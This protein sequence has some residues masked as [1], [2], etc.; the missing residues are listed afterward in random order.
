MSDDYVPG[1]LFPQR[2]LPMLGYVAVQHSQMSHAV[3]GMICH[4][5]N[6]ETVAA[7][8]I[9]SVVMSL[10]M[11]LDIMHRLVITT[12]SD[13]DDQDKLFSLKSCASD[14]NDQRNRIMHDR[15]YF[16][17]PSTDTVGYFRAENLT[18]PQIKTQAPTEITIE[19]LRALGD[20]MLQIIIWLGMYYPRW[21]DCKH[22]KWSDDAQFPWPDILEKNRQKRQK[23]HRDQS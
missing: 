3:D 13:P 21:P 12:V 7:T 10:R 6:M 22:P 9:T 20:E 11:R 14:L 17:S 8:A 18:T 15:Q 4:L 16:F 19:S 2:F 5:S 23:R 1:T